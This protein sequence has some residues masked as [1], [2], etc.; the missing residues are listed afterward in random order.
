MLCDKLGIRGT[1]YMTAPNAGELHE[2]G[3]LIDK[4][5]VRPIVSGTLPLEEARVGQEILAHEHPFGKLVLQ[6]AS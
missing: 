5:K 2:I 4:K 1:H 6:L 3:D